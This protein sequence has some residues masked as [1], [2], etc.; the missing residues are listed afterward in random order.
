MGVFLF[1]HKLRVLAS[2]EIFRELDM[3]L[4][5]S[6]SK[7]TGFNF[8]E[9]NLGIDDRLNVFLDKMIGRIP[10][11]GLNLQKQEDLCLRR[12][13]IMAKIRSSGFEN[14]I[15]STVDTERRVTL[16][17]SYKIIFCWNLPVKGFIKT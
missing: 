11:Q 14:S 15:E 7:K 5:F 8:I 13:L 10:F 17:I 12:S 4:E 9:K 2:K 1:Q 3:S 16:F 6:E